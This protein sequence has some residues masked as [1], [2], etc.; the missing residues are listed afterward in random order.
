MRRS[1]ALRKD[2]W[3]AEEEELL[4]RLAEEGAF[5]RQIASATGRTQTAVAARALRLGVR[6][7]SAP[8]LK[9]TLP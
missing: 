5:V 2:A 7:R 1:V 3:K 6:V 4:R 8:R 9:L